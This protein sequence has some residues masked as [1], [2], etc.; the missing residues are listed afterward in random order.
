MGFERRITRRDVLR[1]SSRIAIGATASGLFTTPR[2]AGAAPYVLR[3]TWEQ[4]NVA[5]VPT[6]FISP[7]C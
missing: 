2:H 6:P 4:Q 5:L 7:P 1:V 3:H